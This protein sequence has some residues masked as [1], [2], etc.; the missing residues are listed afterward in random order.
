[1]GSELHS[2]TNTKNTKTTIFVTKNI[3]GDGKFSIQPK[4][5]K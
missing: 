4:T 1:M 2:L 5:Q 3:C